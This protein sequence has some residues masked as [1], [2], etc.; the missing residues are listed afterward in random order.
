LVFI[1]IS[2]ENETEAF[3]RR[4]PGDRE[5]IRLWSSFTAMDLLRRK[6]M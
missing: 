2:S 1:A 3:E 4:F 6:L 5:R